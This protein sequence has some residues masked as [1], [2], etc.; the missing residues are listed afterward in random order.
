MILL[1]SWLVRLGRMD[2]NGQHRGKTV[3]NDGFL[4]IVYV[5]G[6]SYGLEPTNRPCTPAGHMWFDLQIE[7]RERLI[8]GVPVRQDEYLFNTLQSLRNSFVQQLNSSLWTHCE[9]QAGHAHCLNLI[10]EQH[11]ASDPGSW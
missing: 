1:Y 6:V 8:P 4:G 10:L 9:E 7:P 3:N 11:H 2:S 5:P